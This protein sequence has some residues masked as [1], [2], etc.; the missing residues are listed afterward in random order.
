MNKRIA[1]KITFKLIDYMK[2][3]TP[4]YEEMDALRVCTSYSNGKAIGH[5]L[6]SKLN[7]LNKLRSKN[8]L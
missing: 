6:S 3:Y 2:K 7:K 8:K 1:K 4:N 5:K